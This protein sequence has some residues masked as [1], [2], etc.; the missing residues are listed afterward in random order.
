[1]SNK[2]RKKIDELEVKLKNQ[3]EDF[4]K[5]LQTFLEDY[6]KK[7]EDIYSEVITRS[8][9]RY[10]A[11]FCQMHFPKE[12]THSSTTWDEFFINAAYN[13]IKEVA[14]LNDNLCKNCGCCE[15]H[16]ACEKLEN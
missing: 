7:K 16:C 3:S 13:T 12:V 8:L 4:E 15:E 10:S 14:F 9:L 5:S 11:V 1:M 6:T 2:K